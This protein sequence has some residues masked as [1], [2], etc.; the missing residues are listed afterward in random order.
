MRGIVQAVLILKNWGCGNHS[1]L[2]TGLRFR[3]RGIIP[4]ISDFNIPL[5]ELA[6]CT[7]LLGKSFAMSLIVAGM[8]LLFP[9]RKFFKVLAVLAS[10][11][12]QDICYLLIGSLDYPRKIIAAMANPIPIQ[13]RRLTVSAKMHQPTITVRTAA[14]TE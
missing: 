2:S 3:Y 13:C 1:K 5:V 12:G 14:K 11:H 10:V 6:G 9:V 7:G 4:L 8:L